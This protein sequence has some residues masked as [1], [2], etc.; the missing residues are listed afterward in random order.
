MP[1][2]DKKELDIHLKTQKPISCA[3]FFGAC[4]YLAELYANTILQTAGEGADILKMYFDEYSFSDAKSFLSQ[5]SLFGDKLVLLLKSD[6]KIPKTDLKELISVA[7]KNNALFIYRFFGDLTNKDGEYYKL[8]SAEQNSLFV[9]F[10]NP[11]SMGESAHYVDAEAQKR[12]LDIGK[13]AVEE[14]LTLKNMDLE[15]SVKELDKFFVRDKKIDAKD[16]RALVEES[17]DMVIENLFEDILSKKEF[18]KNLFKILEKAEFDEVRVILFFQNYIYEMLLFLLYSQAYGTIDAQK[19]TGRPLPDFVART[20][21]SKAIKMNIATYSKIMQILLET[22][23]ELKLSKNS[24]KKA[25]LLQYLIKL[26][27]NL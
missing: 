10:F 9:R 4:D 12:G 6:K 7:D 22:D 17:D 11:N 23:F 1:A 16:I 25:I 8:F 14:L 26:Q 24:D 15:A 2:M 21:A 5:N 18:A 19:I 3:M 13:D 27:N 20:K